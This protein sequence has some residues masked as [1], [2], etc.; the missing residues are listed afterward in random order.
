MIFFRVETNLEK[1]K[2]LWNIFTEGNYIYDDWGFRYSYYKYFNYPLHFYVINDGKEE[3]GLL[4][5]QF[6]TDLDKL[7]FF[8]GGFMLKNKVFK[9]SNVDILPLLKVI[10]SSELHRLT[11]DPDLENVLSIEDYSYSLQLKMYK[12]YIDY[13]EDKWE[14]K[15]KKKLLYQLRSIQK[16]NPKVSYNN[17]SDFELFIDL[18]KSRF[19]SDSTFHKPFRIE[20]YKNIMKI[21]HCELISIR[22]GEE[23]IACGFGLLYKKVFYGFTNGNNISYNHIGKYL[24]MMKIDR[25]IQLG[26]ELYDA[27][28]D[29]CGWKESFRFSKEPVYSL[30]LPLNN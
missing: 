4:P 23:L 17:W 1:C 16:L 13:I 22:V 29:D 5:L 26:A 25:A 7:E 10:D 8:G 9:K 28:T 20:F 3:V 14:S 24:N 11:F 12:N 18:N 15:S 30:K 6:N 27:R 2:Y 21:F 19:S